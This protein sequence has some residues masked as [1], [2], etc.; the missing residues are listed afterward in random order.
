MNKSLTLLLAI[1]LLTGLISVSSN[2]QE[3]Q[4]VKSVIGAGGVI[5][6]TNSSDD[7]PILSGI[8]GQSII[9]IRGDVAQTLNQGFWIPGIVDVVSVNNDDFAS[10]NTIYNYP[11]PVKNATTIEYNLEGAAFVTLKIYDMA[12]NEVKVLQDGYQSA[13]T[14]R[15]E[16]NAKNSQGIDVGAG[17]Y[18]YELQVRSASMTGASSYDSF[19]LRNIMVVVR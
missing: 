12:G 10:Q 15:I 16:W 14:Q 3:A 9:E 13:G 19:S 5:H 2:A 8:L 17:S 6:T 1:A 4:L 18:L 11:N 7:T